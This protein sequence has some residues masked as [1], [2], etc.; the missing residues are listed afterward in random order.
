MLAPRSGRADAADGR[1]AERHAQLDRPAGPR[2]RR[3]PRARPAVAARARR[4]RRRVDRR[5]QR[6]GVRRAGPPAARRARG[7][8][9]SR[10]T[11]PARTSRTAAWSSPATRGAAAAVVGAVRRHTAPS[12]CRCFAKLSPDVTDIVD[13]RPGLRRRRRRRPVDDQHA[14]RHGHRPRHDAAGARRRHRRAVRA[15]DPAGRGALRLAGAR[16]PARTCRSSAWAASRTGLDALELVLAGACAVSRRHRDLPRPVRAGPGAARARARRSPPAASTGSPTPSATPTGQPDRRRRDPTGRRP[17]TSSE[18]T[19]DA[20]ARSRSP[21]TPPTSR[22]PS[23][24]ARAVGPHVQHREGRARALPARRRRRGARVP[25]GQRRPRR[26]PRPQAA[27]HPQH[28]RRCG[29]VGRRARARRTSP[30]TPAAAPAMVRAAVEALPDTPGR[31]GHRAHVA[32]RG[33]TST[34]SA[35]PGRRATPCAGSRCSRSSAGARA[36]VCSPHEVAA[37]RAEVGPD[38]TL[39]TPGVR[40]GRAPTP[41]T[42]RGSRRRSRH[43]PTA[44]TCSSS[45]GRSPVPTGRRGAAAARDRRAHRCD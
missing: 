18:A 28:R 15:G 12:A 38:I 37:V 9:P 33:A 5:R 35:S 19:R 10:S 45:V 13:D 44:P 6:R 42:R 7:C 17:T 24:W 31:G 2:H 21:S 39:I 4:A 14:A 40:P 25:R 26:V 27:R 30:C 29:P 32:V 22:P 43:S 20:R 41:A 3:L 16:G 23:R 8:R 34:P 36:L 1:D 11:S